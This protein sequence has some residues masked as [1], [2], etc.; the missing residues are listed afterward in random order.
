MK[1]IIGKNIDILVITETKI[2]PSF[3]NS[4]FQIDGFSMPFRFDRNR[5]GGGVIIYVRDDIPSKQL[6]RHKLPEDIEG[7]FIE[8]NLRKSK[9]L[10]SGTYRPPCQSAEYIFKH[11]GFALDTYI[12]TYDT[13]LLAGDFNIEDHEPILSEFLVNYDSKNLVKEKTCFKSN[14]N[15]RCI[16]LFITNK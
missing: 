5:F 7:I 14:E 16:D 11:I 9:W 15:P 8:V 2:D 4:Q 13:F 6:T 3:P 1:S 12:Q 10:I